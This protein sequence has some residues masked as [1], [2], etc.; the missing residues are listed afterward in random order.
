MGSALECT[1]GISSVD[2][3][4]IAVPPEPK[5]LNQF[6]LTGKKALVTGAG[7]GIGRACAV[8]LAEAG[9]DVAVH[10]RRTSPSETV[11]GVEAAGRIARTYQADFSDRSQLQDLVD[12][13]ISDFGALDILVNNAG[14]NARR[15][16]ED[17][18]EEDWDRILTTNLDAVW[19]L[20]QR[21]GKVV[22][23]ASTWYKMIAKHRWDRP[24]TRVHPAKP[25]IG[26]KADRSNQYWHIDATVVR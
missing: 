1:L 15:P 9:A 19:L 6:D 23:S 4:D 2:V 22:A 16:S 20:C 5:L 12:N 17:F 8:G 21:A 10:T 3:G 26:L 13:V 11:H 25:K 7:R 14:V 18:P 24:R